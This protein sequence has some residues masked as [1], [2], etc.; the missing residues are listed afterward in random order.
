MQE[1]ETYLMHV[2]ITTLQCLFIKNYV[3]GNRKEYSGKQ[4]NKQTKRY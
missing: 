1:G 3:K 4:T 2:L